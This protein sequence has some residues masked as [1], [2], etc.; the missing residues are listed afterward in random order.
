MKR[1]L[2]RNRVMRVAAFTLVE[3]LV[4]IGI[5]ALLIS[6]LLPTLS[7]ARGAA[8]TVQCASNMRQ[9]AG[10]MLMYVSANKGHF[11]PAAYNSGSTVWPDGFWWPN[12]LVQGK[13]I[14]AT[15]VYAA[16]NS[17]VSAKNLSGPNVFRCPEGIE[18]FMSSTNGGDFPY[19]AQNRSFYIHND[20]AAAKAGFG[21][22]SWY[23]LCCRN[24]S[25]TNNNQGARQTPFVYFNSANPSDLVDPLWQRTM[26][27]VKKASELLM[28]VEATSP[29][30]F[31]QTAST[32]FPNTVFLR[33]LAARHG[34]VTGD[35]ANAW[36]NMAFFDGH[37]AYYETVKFEN[38]KDMMDNQRQE[39]IF[40]LNKQ[41]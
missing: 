10:A 36:T 4:V 12:A 25:A 3:L 18:E 38:P 34:K 11:P 2:P 23:E 29:N 7:K 41:Q 14:S 15:N 35:G 16:P 9:I 32:K 21:I 24:L 8:K 19:D 27:R 37:V 39:V 20:T 22:V 31:D 5:I 17:N 1:M 40:Y 33:R 13:Y 6:I 30:W 28:V 26:S